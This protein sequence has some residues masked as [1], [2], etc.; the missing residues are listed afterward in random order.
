MTK[1][2]SHTLSGRGMERA[3][4]TRE[5]WAPR[6]PTPPSGRVC[7]HSSGP[8]YSAQGQEAAVS[9]LGPSWRHG[10]RWASGQSGQRGSQWPGCGLQAWSW[11]HRG[12]SGAGCQAAPIPFALPPKGQEQKPVRF[13]FLCG[14]GP[15]TL[16]WCQPRSKLQTGRE[17]PLWLG[18]EGTP[19]RLPGITT[20]FTDGET[21]AQGVTFRVRVLFGWSG[22][23]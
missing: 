21:E 3:L 16:P 7:G 22:T 10:W 9:S 20:H 11:L 8:T 2:E 12:R 1:N 13:C 23:L 15:R 14:L 5:I 4:N 18:P 19:Q 6:G 17:D